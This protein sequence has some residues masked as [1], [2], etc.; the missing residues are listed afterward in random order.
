VNTDDRT[1]P[2]R[3]AAACAVVVALLVVALR[4][5]GRTWWC[6]CG[7]RAWWAGDV[8]SS[9]M[10]QHL[11]DPYSATHVLHGVL[12]YGGFR[13]FAPQWSLGARFLATTIVEACWEVQ[14]NTNYVINRYR[15]AT[16]AV[17]YA[18]DSIINSL[19]DVVCC[20]VGFWAAR[21]LGL[22]GSIG[23][24]LAV[25]LVLLFTVRD[26]LTLNVLM[27]FVPL[28]SVKAWQAGT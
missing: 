17:G 5:L 2:W 14:E 22:F 8:M 16:I 20:A 1:S 15:Q 21:R 26:N 23:L 25:E 6:I 12:L 18:G 4:L 28:E 11:L 27:L 19:A 7:S 3:I 9:H 10:S 13:Y 24:V